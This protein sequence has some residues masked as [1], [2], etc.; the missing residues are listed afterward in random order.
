MF[1]YIIKKLGTMIL[2]LA[3]TII[4]LF[5]FYVS[6]P[7]DFA[8]AQGPME[9]EQKIAIR[10]KL[11]LDESNAA[12]FMYW[13]KGLLKGS[14]GNSFATG[15]SIN[16][17]LFFCLGNTLKL[18]VIS[19][20]VS[21]AIAL[22]IGIK[23]AYKKNSFFDRFFTVLSLVGISVPAFALA[24]TCKYLFTYNNTVFDIFT[25]HKTWNFMKYCNIMIHYILP[26]IITTLINLATLTKYARSSMLDV[27]LQDYVRTARAKGLKERKVIYKHAFKNALIPIITII[28]LSIPQIFAG[29]YFIEIV[30]GYPGI[31]PLSYRA[32]FMRDYPTMMGISVVFCIVILLANLLTD[33]CYRLIDPR[34]KF[35]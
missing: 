34:I 22:P 29:S 27:I 11:H 12:Q 24:V 16:S 33:I 8:S 31:G 14:L 17:E 30:L 18:N 2:V 35:N 19:F 10:H 20:L 26:Y 4:V 28:G 32:V 9:V 7:A 3:C 15:E 5:F 21:L 13:A 1:T 25:R 6:L 23:S